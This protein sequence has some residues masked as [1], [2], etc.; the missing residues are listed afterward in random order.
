[1]ILSVRRVKTR[2]P[3][4]CWGCARVMPTGTEMDVITSTDEGISSDYWC[5]VCQVVWSD[6]YYA[7]DRVGLGDVKANDPGEWERMRL[8][9]EEIG[10]DDE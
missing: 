3:H 1:M 2:K 10:G 5:D 7:D 6:G 8:L 9:K 4:A